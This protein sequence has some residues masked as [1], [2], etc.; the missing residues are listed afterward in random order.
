MG[1]DNPP[2]PVRGAGRCAALPAGA[3]AAME[4]KGEAKGE[5]WAFRAG[6]G[7]AA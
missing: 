3:D 4:A 5:A 2:G 1:K 6:L 7:F